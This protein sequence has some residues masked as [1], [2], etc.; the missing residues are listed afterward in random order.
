MCSVEGASLAL[1]ATSTAIGGYGMV[2]QGQ[3]ANKQAQ[4]SATISRRNAVMAERAAVDA[5]DKGTRDEASIRMQYKQLK[6]RQRAAFA[7][8]G[9]VVD[10]G[11]A[12]D[13][14]MDTVALGEYDA[15]TTRNNAAKEAFNLREQGDQFNSQAWMQTLAGRDAQTA[16][17]IGAGSTLLSGASTVADKW[18]QYREISAKGTG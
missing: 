8:N 18:Y 13:I 9:V 7:A 10:Q 15:I 11:S 1:A 14:V 17:Y 4:Y 16:G 2:K 12:L 6:G 3:S 5:L